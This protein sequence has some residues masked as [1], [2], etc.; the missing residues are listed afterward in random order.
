MARCTLAEAFFCDLNVS[1][2]SRHLRRGEAP[3]DDDINIIALNTHPNLIST[4]IIIAVSFK[5]ENIMNQGSSHH[6]KYTLLWLANLR[7]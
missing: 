5:D 7:A 4:K 1:G 6:G 2:R 3:N